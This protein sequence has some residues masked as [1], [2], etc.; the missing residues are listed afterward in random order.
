M[1]AYNPLVGRVKYPTQLGVFLRRDHRK[2]LVVDRRLAITGGLNI[3]QH[4]LPFHEGGEAWRDVALSVEGPAAEAFAQ[5]TDRMANV[6]KE[7]HDDHRLAVY[8]RRLRRHRFPEVSETYTYTKEKFLH[9]LPS[10]TKKIH[11]TS[12]AWWSAQG[13]LRKKLS[14]RNGAAEAAEVEE[15]FEVPMLDK[16]KESDVGRLMPSLRIAS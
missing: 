10:L 11:P 3:T 2:L 7:D 8:L 1:N 15:E 14:F 13:W 6:L 9:L 16:L 5:V 12:H 4:W